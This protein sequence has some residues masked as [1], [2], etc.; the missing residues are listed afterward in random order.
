MLLIGALLMVFYS[1]IGVL[2]K[3]HDPL[4][5]LAV[6]VPRINDIYATAKP[7]VK[8]VEPL[9]TVGTKT[10]ETMTDATRNVCYR[11]H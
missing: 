7:R 10:T 3:W 4:L 6:R 9:T 8:N 1:P 2:N 5:N 11:N